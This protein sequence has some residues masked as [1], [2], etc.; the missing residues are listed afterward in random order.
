MTRRTSL[1]VRVLAVLM[2]TAGLHA[3]QALTK[4]DSATMLR[5]LRAIEARGAQPPG[6]NGVPLRTSFTDREVNAYFKYDGQPQLPV[7]VGSPEIV[8]A[9]GGKIE[10]KAVVDLDAVRKAQSNAML[11]FVA[12][13]TNSVEV[14]AFGRLQTADGRGTLVIDRATVGGFSVPKSVLQS[15]VSHYSK[16]PDQPNGFDLDKPFDLPAAIRAV[17]LQRGSAVIVQ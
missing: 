10:G 2:L 4:E 13:F 16:T 5:K 8:I 7:G 1:Y 6:K 15:V 17:E 11:D 12:M 14:R 9:D 3:G